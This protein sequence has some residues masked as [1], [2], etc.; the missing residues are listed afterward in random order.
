MKS[1]TLL[2]AIA[3]LLALPAAAQIVYE[4]GPINGNTDAWTINFGFVV[5]RHA[6]PYRLAPLPSP[7]C[8]LALG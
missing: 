8:P 6:S 1:F 7:V 5:S 2:L 3:A 4:N